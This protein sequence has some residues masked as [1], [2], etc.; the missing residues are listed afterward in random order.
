MRTRTWIGQKED[1]ISLE[2]RIIYPC[3]C[4]E[5]QFD[6]PYTETVETW[7]CS[8]HSQEFFKEKSNASAK[9]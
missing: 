4:V 6:P 5:R 9:T 8:K 7:L 2:G 1:G 3:G